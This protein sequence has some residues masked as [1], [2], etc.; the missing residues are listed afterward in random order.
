MGELVIAAVPLG[1]IGD[2]SQRLRDVIAEAELVLAEDSR[3]FVR[4]CRDL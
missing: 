1:N 3:R 4:L 2:A